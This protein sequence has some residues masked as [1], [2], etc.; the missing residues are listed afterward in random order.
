MA[1]A[2]N[3]NQSENN[4]FKGDVSLTKM[5]CKM[6]VIDRADMDQTTAVQLLVH[7]LNPKPKQGFEGTEKQIARLYLIFDSVSSW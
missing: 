6:A 4:Q 5:G 2:D 3:F 7:S 1:S